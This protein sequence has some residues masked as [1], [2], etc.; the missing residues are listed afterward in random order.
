MIDDDNTPSTI[1]WLHCSV[2]K[3]TINMNRV[4]MV[5][6]VPKPHDSVEVVVICDGVREGF[7]FTEV[8]SARCFHNELQS[9]LNEVD[10]RGRR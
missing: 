8:E 3:Y 1:V 7:V 4:S 10:V 5:K 9:G 2:E 6:W